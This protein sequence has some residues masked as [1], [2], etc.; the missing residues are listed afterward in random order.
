MKVGVGMVAVM[1]AETCLVLF[2]FLSLRRSSVRCVARPE[3]FL[4]LIEPKTRHE[5]GG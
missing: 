3:Y 5:P 1:Q 2:L 4:V